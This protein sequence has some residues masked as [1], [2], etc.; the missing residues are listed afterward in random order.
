MTTNTFKEI[1]FCPHT[2]EVYFDIPD[3]DKGASL[4]NHRFASLFY[5][6]KEVLLTCCFDCH[7]LVVNEHKSQITRFIRYFPKKGSP[8][9]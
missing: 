6:V 9:S 2:F 8:F 1:Y 5:Q 7:E 4:C 3:K